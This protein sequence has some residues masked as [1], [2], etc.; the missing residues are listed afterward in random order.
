M[1]FNSLGIVG[2]LLQIVL[3][4]NAV[5]LFILILFAIPLGFVYRDLRQTLNRFGIELDPSQLTGEKEELYHNAASKVFEDDPEVVA[6]IYGHTHKPSIHQMENRYV[7]DT[8]TWL[9]KFERIS[10]RF[11]LLPAI[12]VPTYNL[13]FFRLSEQNGNITI[14]YHRIDKAP[15]QELT[16]IQRLM[17]SRKR[18]KV[19]IDIPEKTT[20]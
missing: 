4:I 2:S 5:V 19:I 6:F 14:E 8:G 7:I 11:G 18:R 1:V 16:I 15:P 13:N 3:T 9:K 12:Y 20:I 17:V 10:P